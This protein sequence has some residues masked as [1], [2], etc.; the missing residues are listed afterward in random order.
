MTDFVKD[1]LSIPF[2]FGF[3]YFLMMLIAFFKKKLSQKKG[4]TLKI[5]INLLDDEVLVDMYKI[6]MFA[7]K[8]LM[9]RSY[10]SKCIKD[11][12]QVQ[13]LDH[14]YL[15]NTYVFDNFN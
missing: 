13:E 3:G 14:D 15:L 5:N 1:I 2:L 10:K 4:K 7:K 6:G 12:D 11:L 9:T 8:E